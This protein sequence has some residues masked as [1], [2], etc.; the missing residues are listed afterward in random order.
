[1]CGVKKCNAEVIIAENNIPKRAAYEMKK[2]KMWR[3][4]KHNRTTT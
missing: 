1:M 2:M 4:T 3:K